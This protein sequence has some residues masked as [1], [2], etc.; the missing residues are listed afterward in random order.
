MFLELNPFG[1]A[2]KTISP[3]GIR[4]NFRGNQDL[5]KN[6]AY[7]PLVEQMTSKF[8]QGKTPTIVSEPEAIATIIYEAATDGKD[9]LRYPAGP[10][11]LDYLS[12]RQRLGAEGFRR[13]LTELF[14]H[15]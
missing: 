9:Q 2:V 5:T 7:T 12:M 13:H 6:D 4:S 10:D 14:F 15:S 3:G 1:I 8:M 11:A